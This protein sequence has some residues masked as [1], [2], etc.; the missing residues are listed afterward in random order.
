MC[1]SECEDDISI[2]T[3]VIVDTDAQTKRRERIWKEWDFCKPL[4]PKCVGYLRF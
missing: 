2:L 1:T 4:V 3:E